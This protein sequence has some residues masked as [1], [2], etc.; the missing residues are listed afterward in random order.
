MGY[1]DAE[2]FHFLAFDITGL[3]MKTT[4]RGLNKTVRRQTQQHQISKSAR[5]EYNYSYVGHILY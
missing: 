5:L 1:Y 2:E 4:L 3:S